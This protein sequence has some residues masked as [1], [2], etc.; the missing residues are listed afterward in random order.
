MVFIHDCSVTSQE[1]L[2]GIQEKEEELFARDAVATLVMSAF[3]HP[4][5]VLFCDASDFNL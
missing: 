2:V 1:L 3:V 4:V 5:P